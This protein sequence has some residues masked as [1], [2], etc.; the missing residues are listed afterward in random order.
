MA[1]FQVVVVFTDP[2]AGYGSFG[3]WVYIGDELPDENDVVEI[4]LR[5]GP[6][7]IVFA[8]DR[9]QARVT[10]IDAAVGG[11]VIRA[12]QEGPLPAA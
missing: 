9:M 4:H 11:P 1:E 3:G 5:E 12:T 2:Q 6:P 7:D 8:F 10:G